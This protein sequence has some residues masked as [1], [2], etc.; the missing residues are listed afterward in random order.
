MAIE[1]RDAH[2]GGDGLDRL[3]AENLAAL[4]AKL[5]LLAGVAGQ[6]LGFGAN[7][8]DDIERNLRGIDLM[9]DGF[10]GDPGADLLVELGD[11]GIAGTG[12]GL[13]RAADDALDGSGSR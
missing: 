10:A 13:I 1:N 4:A 11:G 6:V 3:I 12:D 8:R 2:T 9:G 7:L 5:G